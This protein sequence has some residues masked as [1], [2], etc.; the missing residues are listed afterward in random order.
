MEIKVPPIKINRDDGLE[1][2]NRIL[3]MSNE[4]RKKL[5][6][7]KSTLWYLKKN[8]MSKDKIKIYD[9]IL[10]KLQNCRM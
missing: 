10:E 3:S 9:K 4:E 1:L 6:I 7:N 8:V 2:R 5:E